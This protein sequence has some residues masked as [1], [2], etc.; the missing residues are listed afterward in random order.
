MI[1]ESV[2]ILT[3]KHVNCAK[4]IN[5]KGVRNLPKKYN[6]L[7]K[8]LVYIRKEKKKEKTEK[9]HMSIK[10]VKIEVMIILKTMIIMY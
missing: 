6:V 4:L 8:E 7:T 2:S 3:R 9:V 5:N 10:I 1:F